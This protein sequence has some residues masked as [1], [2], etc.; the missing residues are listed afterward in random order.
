MAKMAILG[1]TQEI[2]MLHFSQNAGSISGRFHPIFIAGD[3]LPA[4]KL[5]WEL[6]NSKMPQC[7]A[8]G[9]RLAHLCRTK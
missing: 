3:H 4:L 7:N 5:M 1:L 8:P 2:K 6:C 9:H